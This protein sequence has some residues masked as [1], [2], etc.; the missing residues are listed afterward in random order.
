VGQEVLGGIPG[1]GAFQTPLATLHK[2]NGWADLFLTTP[3][4]GLVD[5][6]ASIAG[7]ADAFS[8]IVMLHDY[9]SHAGSTP[10]GTELDAELTWTSPW[11]QAFGVIWAGYDADS[12]ASD[13]TKLWVFTAYRFGLDF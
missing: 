8:W 2:F 11:K 4:T 12:F 13:T 5:T 7:K 3:P 10:Y 9:E 6:W 1:E